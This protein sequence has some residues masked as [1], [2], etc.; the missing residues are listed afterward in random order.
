MFD[1]GIVCIA[2]TQEQ[3]VSNHPS[4]AVEMETGENY[5]LIE[6]FFSS[7]SNVLLL[8]R[9]LHSLFQSGLQDIDEFHIFITN[10]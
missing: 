9:S 7:V 1:V 5:V 10:T 3:K 8:S 6:D 2:Q 4:Q